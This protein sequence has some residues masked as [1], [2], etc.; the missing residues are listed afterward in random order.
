MLGHAQDLPCNSRLQE[1][2][3]V[4]QFSQTSIKKLMRMDNLC[5]PGLCMVPSQYILSAIS[6]EQESKVIHFCHKMQ[7]DDLEIPYLDWLFRP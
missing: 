6:R 4:A 5:L 3:L 2:L 7:L 1:V